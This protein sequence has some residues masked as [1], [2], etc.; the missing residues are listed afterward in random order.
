MNLEDKIEIIDFEEKYQAY[1]YDLNVE[2]IKHF[3]EIEANDIKYLENSKKNIIDKGGSIKFAQL[4]GEIV[5]TCALIKTARDEF[6]LAKMAVSPKAQGKKIGYYL[7]LEI[8]KEAKK[9]G[10]K[11]VF[12]LSNTTLISAINLYKKLGFKEV[13]LGEEKQLY[14]RVDIKM[15]LLL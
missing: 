13:E 5:G 4:N 12:L 11:K 15:E 14:K 8:I 1:F 2:W 7:A 6:E 3:F 10:A 9:L